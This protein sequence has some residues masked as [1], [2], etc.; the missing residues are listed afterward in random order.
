MCPYRQ[1]LLAGSA[2]GY[3]ALM[4]RTEP[5]R[6][7]WFRRVSLHL[8][9]RALHLGLLVAGLFLVV[10]WRGALL[11]LADAAPEYHSLVTLDANFP[12][13]SELHLGR[14]ELMQLPGSRS[15]AV[16]HLRVFEGVDGHVYLSLTTGERR[17]YLGFGP[18]RDGTFSD[19]F[20]VLPAQVGK[21]V[22]TELSV[23]A[24]TVTIEH[25]GQ[26]G[27]KV[28]TTDAA[29]DA[30]TVLVS[31]K[32]QL[33]LADGMPAPACYPTLLK[34]FGDAYRAARRGFG[35][36]RT[37]LKG[38]SQH[39]AVLG[40]DLT[41][42]LPGGL[43]LIAMPA[44]DV[45]TEF[46]LLQSDDGARTQVQ[47]RQVAPG[48]PVLYRTL[49]REAGALKELASHA[50]HSELHWRLHTDQSGAGPS[51]QSFT[52]GFTRY[53]ITIRKGLSHWHL[54]VQPVSKI[55]LFPWDACFGNQGAGDPGSVTFVEARPRPVFC[56]P[57]WQLSHLN[58]QTAVKIEA[59][60]MPAQD[61]LSRLVTDISNDHLS[62]L[63][64]VVRWAGL[65]AIAVFAGYF[66]TRGTTRV[67]TAVYLLPFGLCF[68]SVTAPEWTWAVMSLVDAPVATS[69]RFEAMILAWIVATVAISRF[70]LLSAAFWLALGLVVL[71][72][73]ASLFAMSAEG[74]S[75]DWERFFIKHKLFVLD[76]VP[77]IAAAVATASA[78]RLRS[79]LGYDIAGRPG[80]VLSL[81]GIVVVSVIA[82]FLAWFFVGNQ[83]GLG[84][85][86]QPVEAG[87]L[88]VVLALAGVVVQWLIHA[89]RFRPRWFKV[90]RIA[91][92]SIFIMLLVI[93]F[94][95][96]FRSDYSPLIIVFATLVMT[97]TVAVGFGG[98]RVLFEAA[99]DRRLLVRLPVSFVPSQGLLRK[100]DAIWAAIAS[101][102]LGLFLVAIGGL[103]WV[104]AAVFVGMALS[105]AVLIRW[106]VRR[107]A[108]AL[109]KRRM[110]QGQR[111]TGI[112]RWRWRREDY[113]G[114][115]L[116][117]LCVAAIPLAWLLSTAPMRL[118][119]VDNWSWHATPTEQIEALEAALGEGR[120]LPK[121]RVLSWSDM[122]YSGDPDAPGQRRLRYRD[123]NYQ[124]MR[125]R[126]A[127][128]HAAPGMAPE[129]ELTCLRLPFLGPPS[130]HC[131]DK[132]RAL[133]V[134]PCEPAALKVPV[135]IHC[136]P[137]VQSDF[138]AT[139]LIVRLGSGSAKL[140]VAAQGAVFVLCLLGFFILQYRTS[141]DPVSTGA[142]QALACILL[143]G[144]FLFLSQWILSWGN[145]FGLLPVM[146]Q[147]MTW[148]S[149]ATS[150]H[151]FAAIPLV[152]FS[153]IG[154]KVAEQR[155]IRLEFGTPPRRTRSVFA[156]R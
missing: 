9:G 94:V 120:R 28:Q 154:F 38:W 135:D 79:A 68:V 81:L 14:A 21:A 139:H 1:R 109:V 47:P 147:P 27:Y 86:F 46:R 49:I 119:D 63:E 144:G 77:L 13:G 148:L 23:G 25:A 61:A 19:R 3:C 134:L 56:P 42:Q 114:A 74:P 92:P 57:D 84:G 124:V 69:I 143:G 73:G 7:P 45:A 55:H 131:T 110:R 121:L 105:S 99:Q 107:H 122:R 8:G 30:V 15:A 98:A 104:W 72:G 106:L 118:L 17:L 149:A 66:A 10:W 155:Q 116:V 40:G 29:G 60:T 130:N 35:H 123:Q 31:R 95:P 70:G 5:S 103:G 85:A 152:F 100:R 142:D 58:A 20:E 88:A 51:V 33:S 53:D 82:M 83:Q 102:G 65:F 32:G 101:V 18:D 132:P 41:C 4:P 78:Q 108:R 137:V 126:A 16:E 87:K 151:L 36:M 11:N 2:R 44:A 93:A 133:Q 117:S 97:A 43:A 96:L 71:L 136:V 89:R 156:R 67:K 146:G 54:Q 145:I 91:V 59:T 22:I 128:A 80:Q 34:G 39:I 62:M 141:R 125:S 140:L 24:Q 150:H 90:S 50:G 111:G 48:D 113:W 75:D 153:M 127:I 52:A 76:F 37:W 112:S 12:I 26:Q 129:L 6:G 138:A 115:G 64:K